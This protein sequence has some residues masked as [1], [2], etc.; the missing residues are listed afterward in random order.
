[1][2][3]PRL[4]GVDEGVKPRRRRKNSIPA[5]LGDAT[6]NHYASFS[7]RLLGVPPRPLL[8]KLRKT[9]VPR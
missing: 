4:S 3:L 9:G 8:T 6:E 5:G 7:L 1:V 2:R